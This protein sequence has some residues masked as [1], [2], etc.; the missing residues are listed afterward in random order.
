MLKKIKKL[1]KSPAFRIKFRFEDALPFKKIRF[2]EN[3]V[4]MSKV[5]WYDINFETITDTESP[6]KKAIELKLNF[7]LK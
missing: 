7:D 5:V 6:F 2:N 3:I 4:D 1:I